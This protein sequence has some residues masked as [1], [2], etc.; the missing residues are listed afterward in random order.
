[1]L[2]GDWERGLAEWEW[3]KKL[4][5]A[6]RR[7]WQAWEWRGSV[8]PRGTVLAH[9][10]Q[11]LGDTLQF[12]RFVRNLRMRVPRVV[13]ECQSALIPLLSR[14]EF[15]DDLVAKGATLP[16]HDA[17]VS[18]LSLPH[19]L[20]LKGDGLGSG[21]Y[22][23]ADPQLVAK[24]REFLD[25]LPGRR[26][27]IAWQGNPKYKRDPFR[28]VPLT[29]FAPL[30]DVPGVTLVSLQQGAGR[31]QLDDPATRP[32]F[33]LV[34]PGREVD[35]ASGAFMDTAAIMQGL[36]LVITSD[37]SI[38][39][40]AG[41]LGVPVWLAVSSD[42]DFR[43]GSRGETSPWYPGMRL[44]RQKSEGDWTGVFAA[45]AAALQAAQVP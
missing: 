34:D 30:A 19:A 11:G 31:A 42:P 29:A 6:D 12:I 7:Q 32:A 38:P 43:W 15:I 39:H 25:R 3:R 33:P 8:M 4:P 9:A 2:E 45:M 26:I 10:E 28:S 17:H 24:W 35:T 41:G 5:A 23:S 16:A 37:T 36:D 22:L 44:F 40:L 18:L 20:G 1:M 27:G 21:P 14:C 13:V